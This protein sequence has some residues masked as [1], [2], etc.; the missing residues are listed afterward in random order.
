MSDKTD[1]AALGTCDTD[2]RVSYRDT[3]RMGHVYYANYLV[4]F[5][6]GRTE[7]LRRIGQTYKQWEEEHGVY[8]PVSSC[9]IDYRRSAMYD[10]LVTIRARASSM[11]RASVTFHYEI[12]RAG[13]S[14]LLAAG[15][16]RH[17]LVSADGRILR[18]AQRLLPQCFPSVALTQEAD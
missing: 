17:A 4:W 7:L 15:E 2:V 3:D 10:D 5:E 11:T 9:K 8:L 6:I 18:V 14:E 13:T 1:P 12:F 16:T